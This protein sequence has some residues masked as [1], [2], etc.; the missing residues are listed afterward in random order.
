MP[1]SKQS[2]QEQID[3]LDDLI[4]VLEERL[5]IFC[6]SELKTI[7]ARTLVQ[8]NSTIAELSEQHRK[9]Y[10]LLGLTFQDI[11]YPI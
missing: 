7:C 1:P 3:K 6:E 10:E 9:L 4:K 8:M 5:A 2:K 11:E